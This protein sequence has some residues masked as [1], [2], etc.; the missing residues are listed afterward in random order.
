MNRII[1]RL[2]E[3]MNRHD[4][5]AMAALFAADY[6][7]EQPTH[8]TRGFG[9]PAQVRST[10]SE[11]FRGVADFE[12]GV[13][14]EATEG[15][16]SWSEWVWRGTRGDGEPFLMKGVI[17]LGWREDGLISWARWYM[18]PVEQAG[19][20]IDAAVRQLSGLSG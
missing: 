16:T 12:A 8:P 19:P 4:V 18:E 7:S 11:M 17:V 9:G 3:A 15:P 5:E 6:R 20:S 10:W 14:K 2:R 1:S 13:V